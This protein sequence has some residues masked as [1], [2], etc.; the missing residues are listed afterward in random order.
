MWYNDEYS[1]YSI[2][3]Q[4][5]VDPEIYNKAS[6]WQKRFKEGDIVRIE[7]EWGSG[8]AFITKVVRNTNNPPSGYYLA[9]EKDECEYNYSY[10]FAAFVSHE[11]NKANRFLY[12][13]NGSYIDE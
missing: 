5:Y 12:H 13:M 4:D 10:A 3:D 2:L 11:T 6:E 8:S 9:I 7:R 1:R